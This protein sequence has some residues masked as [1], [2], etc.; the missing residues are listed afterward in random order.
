MLSGTGFFVTD[1]WGSVGYR[2]G[3]PWIGFTVCLTELESREC[4]NWGN[5]LIALSCSLGH[6]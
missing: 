3:L 2:I 1:P 5:A 4:G 6:S